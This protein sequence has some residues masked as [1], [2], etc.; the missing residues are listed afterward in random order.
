MNL[1]K[2]KGSATADIDWFRILRG[3]LFFACLGIWV[4]RWLLLIVGLVR[5]ES[6]YFCWAL[7]SP[8]ES[9]RA[10]HASYDPASS[11]FYRILKICDQMLPLGA[12][13]QI[14]LP[15]EQR[16]KFEFLGGKAR[17]FLYPRNYGDNTIRK[18]YILVYQVD[19]FYRPEGYETLVTFAPDKY[20]LTNRTF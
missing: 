1:A 15:A 5:F 9:L 19:D 8:I 7:R 14:V 4:A 6:N 3:Y 11:D 10:F 20:L 12:E 2:P 16:N 17:Y 18:D 13:L